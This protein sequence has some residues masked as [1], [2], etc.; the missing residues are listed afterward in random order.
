MT[1]EVDGAE[2]AVT[3]EVDVAGD[4]ATSDADVAADGATYSAWVTDSAAASMCGE[5]TGAAGGLKS[6]SE[7]L[8]SKTCLQAP[9]RTMPPRNFNWSAATRNVV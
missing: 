7:A 6:T 1:L 8:P 5:G 9:Q 3:S 4:A 2:N